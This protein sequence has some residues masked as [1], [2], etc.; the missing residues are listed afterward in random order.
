MDTR[1]NSEDGDLEK[2]IV[3]NSCGVGWGGKVG[4]VETNLL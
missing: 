2:K 3:G 4:R 1:L